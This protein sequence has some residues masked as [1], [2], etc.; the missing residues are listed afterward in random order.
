MFLHRSDKRCR[1]V[2][3]NNKQSVT[4]GS[5]RFTDRWRNDLEEKEEE[6]AEAM[7][8]TRGEG[9]EYIS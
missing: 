8:E 7:M 9:A 2:E 4:Y 3:T 6:E 5:S 1:R